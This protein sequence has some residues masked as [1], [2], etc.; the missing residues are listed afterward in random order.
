MCNEGILNNFD[1]TSAVYFYW[2]IALNT[3]ALLLILSSPGRDLMNTSFR[4]FSQQ[5]SERVNKRDKNC[6]TILVTEYDMKSLYTQIDVT[7]LTSVGEFLQAWNQTAKIN[8][9]VDLYHN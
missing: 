1:E 6:L 9:F 8:Q 5:N 3:S 2:E 7:Y 4:I